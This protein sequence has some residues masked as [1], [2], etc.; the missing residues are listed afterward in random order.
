MHVLSRKPIPRGQFCL[1]KTLYGAR[2]RGIAKENL[3]ERMRRANEKSLLGGIVVLSKRANETW[4]FELQTASM[5]QWEA[6]IDSRHAGK[7]YHV[8]KVSDAPMKSCP[9]R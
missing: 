4:D 8:R 7:A 6:P 5:H 9:R 2:S 3:A 1:F